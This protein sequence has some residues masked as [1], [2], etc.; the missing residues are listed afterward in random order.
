MEETRGREAI[1]R[2]TAPKRGGKP[3]TLKNVLSALEARGIV[4]GID[5]LAIISAIKKSRYN[6]PIRVAKAKLTTKGEPTRYGYRFG[7]RQ[8]NQTQP[9][10]RLEVIPGQILAVKSPSEQGKVGISVFG[11]EIPGLLGNDFSQTSGKTPIWK[12]S[13]QSY[14][15]QAMVRQ[16]GLRISAMSKSVYG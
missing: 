9:Q 16:I 7:I 4:Y 14:T 10:D 3:P 6:L 13:A 2:L 8:E 1:I 12:M 11:E 5:E 15:P